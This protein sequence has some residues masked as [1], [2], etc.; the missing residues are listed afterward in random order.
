MLVTR[1]TAENFR[2]YERLDLAVPEGATGI[3]GANGAGKSS[4]LTMIDVGL[5][6]ARSLEP[7]VM[8]GADRLQVQIEVDHAGDQYRIRRGYRAGKTST[9][10]EVCASPTSP[11]GAHIWEPLTL[12]KQ[13]ATQALIERTFG[14][15]RDTFRASAF[16]A[17]GDADALTSA[18]PAERMLILRNTIGSLDVWARAHDRAKALLRGTDRELARI[19]GQSEALEAEAARR[20]D[21][22]A[23]QERLALLAAEHTT[24]L[25]IAESAFAA[26]TEAFQEARGQHA[27]TETL[28]ARLATARA[29]LAGLDRD[30]DAAIQASTS[31]AQEQAREQ[32]FAALA[33]RLPDLEAEEAEQRQQIEENRRAVDAHEAT[34][35]ERALKERQQQAILAQRADLTAKATAAVER[36]RHLEEQGPGHDRCTECAQV[37]G[38]EALDSTLATLRVRADELAAAAR[39]LAV[40]ADAISLPDIGAAPEPLG[41]LRHIPVREAREAAIMLAGVREKLLGLRESAARAAEPAR[42]AEHAAAQEQVIHAEAE[43]DA[44]TSGAPDL[45]QLERACECASDTIDAARGTLDQTR[46]AEAVNTAALQRVVHADLQLA[47]A[48]MQAADQR[49]DQT[50]LQLLADD[51]SPTGIPLGIIETAVPQIEEHAQTVLERLGGQTASCR[52]ELRTQRANK[53]DG[54]LRDTLDIVIHIPEHQTSLEYEHWS[55]G[56]KMRLDLAIRIGLAQLLLLNGANV[57]LFAIDEPDGLDAQGRA[58]LVEIIGE[59]QA[60]YG[61][62]TVL[63]ISHDDGLR[64]SMPNVIEVTR[65]DGGPSVIAGAPA[66]VAELEMVA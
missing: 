33:D 53:T 52:I 58:A 5:F 22:D 44:A 10:F 13:T 17:Q 54:A 2:S 40:Q 45:D 34:G 55:G 4:I 51:F 26:A 47:D 32:E 43:L 24:G 60:E 30:M 46:R 16:L 29:T 57:E 23:E 3:L 35:R 38:Q 63:L 66:P 50:I 39:D 19:G 64:E 37:L 65:A 20:P 56:E 61:F 48:R 41:N 9:D 49:R 1:V 8:F 7:L 14:L 6:G 27:A 15:T 18:K 21:L 36:A 42:V 59:M 11:G 31:I 62:R 28:H 12:E 25:A